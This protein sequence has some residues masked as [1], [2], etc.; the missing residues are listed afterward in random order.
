MIIKTM[1]DPLWRC[2]ASETADDGRDTPT[3]RDIRA[4]RR[5]QG[6][7]DGGRAARQGRPRGHRRWHQSLGGSQVSELGEN[8]TAFT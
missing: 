7:A 5:G 8:R 6:A 3:G 2:N 4:E 1:L